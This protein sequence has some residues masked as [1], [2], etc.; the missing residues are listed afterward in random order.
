MQVAQVARE[1]MDL[2]V[3]VESLS[4]SFRVSHLK[5]E[6]NW[7]AAFWINLNGRGGYEKG[8]AGGMTSM[9]C[10]ELRNFPRRRSKFKYTR[11]PRFLKPKPMKKTGSRLTLALFNN[12][13]FLIRNQTS[14][15]L[16][17]FSDWQFTGQ[18]L[19]T[20]TLLG[21]WSS[22]FYINMSRLIRQLPTVRIHLNQFINVIFI[23]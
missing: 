18:H 13:E 23:Y 6:I 5:M 9:R 20:R 8:G 15:L 16:S 19:S 21:F 7:P 10:R 1:E 11:R 3:R 4:L 2:L 14:L 17:L 22:K 12:V